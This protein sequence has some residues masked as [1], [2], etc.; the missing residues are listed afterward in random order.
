MSKIYIVVF[1]LRFLLKLKF[2]LFDLWNEIKVM[3]R[4]RR[5]IVLEKNFNFLID[6]FVYFYIV[7][8]NI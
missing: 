8:R 6:N 1:L 4:M 2:L 3:L 5:E 7:V